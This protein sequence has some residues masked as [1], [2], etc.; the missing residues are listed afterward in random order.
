MISAKERESRRLAGA[1]ARA[2][3]YNA[4]NGGFQGLTAAE[5]LAVGNAA[6]HTGSAAV[7][8]VSFNRESEPT[9]FS[10]GAYYYTNK[11]ALKERKL[12]EEIT[13]PFPS[14]FSISPLL[15]SCL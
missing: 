12:R 6:M 7:E 1:A 4:D 13:T 11:E 14:L 9:K 5:A 2:K 3:Q 10:D 8:T 15:H